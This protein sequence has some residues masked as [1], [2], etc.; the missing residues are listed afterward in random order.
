MGPQATVLFMQ[1]V[2]DAVPAADDRG[3]IPM[4]VDMNTQVPSRMAHLID[5][6]GE[7]PGPVLAAMARG[8]ESS[9]A[10]ALAMPCN[11]AHHYAARIRAE[12]GLPLLD[13]VA[14]SARAAAEIAGTGSRIG[15]LA[16]PAVKSTGIFDRALAAEGLKVTYPPDK[17]SLLEAIRTLKNRGVCAEAR[18]ALAKAST[19]LFAAGAEVQLIACTEL[20]LIP[21]ATDARASVIDTLDV[22]VREVVSFATSAQR[23]DDC[24]MAG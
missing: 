19:A 14:R 22:L 6:T 4:I 12:V 17:A 20:S 8:L 16:S 3:H 9:G 11:T 23:E 24:R 13:M 10:E 18:D 7:D 21:E 5:G 2:I 1:K 15:M